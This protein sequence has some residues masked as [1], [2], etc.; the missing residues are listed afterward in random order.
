MTQAPVDGFWFKITA[1]GNE[2]EGQCDLATL[3]AMLDEAVKA[4]PAPDRLTVVV[5]R[6]PF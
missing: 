2:T 3:L 4:D 1:D 6:F 5:E